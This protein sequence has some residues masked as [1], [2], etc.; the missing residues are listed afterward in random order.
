MSPLSRIPGLGQSTLELLEAAGFQ[1]AEA[2]ALAEPSALLREL[3]MAN[4]VLR[5]AEGAPSLGDVEGLIRAA[6]AASGNEP[7]ATQPGPSASSSVPIDHERNPEVQRMLAAAP[8]AIPLPSRVLRDR[9]V[10]V[11]D[12][13]AGILLNRYAGDLDV[14]APVTRPAPAVLPAPVV[15]ETPVR[16]ILPASN[17]A[18]EAPPRTAVAPQ[19]SLTVVQLAENTSAKQGL[20]L[21]KVRTFEEAV[22]DSFKIAEPEQEAPARPAPAND[23]VSLLRTPREETNR[24]RDPKS[25]RYIRGV[26]HSQPV[27]I[28]LGALV[29]LPAL[30]LFPLALLAAALLLASVL[31]P[32]WFS[33]VPGWTIVLP[34]ALPVFGLL[35]MTTA[36]GGICRVCGQKLFVHRSHLK[37]PRAHQIRFLGYVLPLC[38]HIL[39]FRWF[40]CSHCGTPIRLKE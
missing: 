6:R 3:Q 10:S 32:T 7:N 16:S 28:Y 39:L 38:I 23:R 27:K 37:N 9:G 34:L 13:P 20:D 4:R 18:P 8:F 33:W 26:L 11:G 30:L 15:Q 1:S 21:K 40:R 19:P 29:T 5:I 22:A 35:W 17:Q 25:R 2:V 24:G 12:I 14:R 36:L 31:F